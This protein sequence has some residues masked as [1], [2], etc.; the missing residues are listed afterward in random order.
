MSRTDV[1]STFSYNSWDLGNPGSSPD[2]RLGAGRFPVGRRA[3]MLRGN[4]WAYIVATL[5]FVGYSAWMIGPYLWSA[6]IR[7][8]AVTSWANVATSPIDGIVDEALLPV[9]QVIGSDG[10]IMTIVN[11]RVTKESVDAA[12]IRAELARTRVAELEEFID[13]VRVLDQGR[14]DLKARYAI[15]F[16]AQLDADIAGLE[17]QMDSARQ[18]LETMRRVAARKDTLV[19]RGVGSETTADEARIQVEDLELEIA[20]LR[21]TLAHSRVRR[22]AANDSVF[23]TADGE[24]PAWVLEDR[25]ELKL[26]KT[27]ARVELR[28][29]QSELALALQALETAKREFEGLRRAVVEAPPGS[30][31]WSRSVAS[32]ATVR[33]G[34]AVA[35]WLDCSDLMVDVPVSDAEVPL[36]RPGMRAE[37][38]LEGESRTREGQALLTRG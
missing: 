36:I 21:A 32:G 12:M 14:G 20:G 9:A 13:E 15:T 18:R 25:L 31:L 26:A 2:F 19:E 8:A 3:T 1:S 17:R 7:D 27:E 5:G 4:H 37:V 6:I 24:D 28:Q 33:A 30:V 23:I 22:E 34:D 16:R 38:I 10:I 29:A 11:E 35:E